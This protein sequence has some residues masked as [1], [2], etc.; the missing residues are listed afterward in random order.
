MR[1]VKDIL[2]NARWG[3]SK[4]IEEADYS[5]L[6]YAADK[7]VEAKALIIIQDSDFEEPDRP[8]KSE[9]D[10]I[11]VEEIPNVKY[12]IPILKVVK[13][14]KYK[15]RG[16]F[17]TNSGNFK[18]PT[19]HYTVSGGSEKSAISIVKYLA[20]KGLGA[21]VISHDGVGYIPED[22]DFMKDVVYHAGSSSWNGRNGVSAHCVGLE[23]CSW[24]K[25]NSKTRK[26]ANVIRSVEAKDNMKAGDYEAFTM[27]QENFW[28]NFHLWQ[29]DVNPEWKTDWMNGHDEISPSRKSDPGGSFSMSMPDARKLIGNIVDK[30]Q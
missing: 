11:V 24:G 12:T 28:L 8:N 22:F 26:R 6:D 19:T 30:W 14:V 16:N 15:L 29:A 25:L 4:G 1:T 23:F 21:I 9:D 2:Y 27:K 18:A 20:K 3:I 7:I 5:K 13:G 17:K 10:H